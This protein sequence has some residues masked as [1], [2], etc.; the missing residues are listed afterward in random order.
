MESSE[1]WANV[2]PETVQLT[3]QEQHQALKEALRKKRTAIRDYQYRQ[4]LL[5]EP[6][7]KKFTTDEYWQMFQKNMPAGFEITKFNQRIIEALCMWSA[8]DPEFERLKEGF[9]LRKGNLLYG[10]YG[11]GKSTIM[12]LF[13][14][15][16]NAS[17]RCVSI[18]N[19]DDEYQRG[20]VQALEKYYGF[21]D[22]GHEATAWFRQMRGGYCFDDIGQEKLVVNHYQNQVNVVSEILT[23]RYYSDASYRHTHGTTNADAEELGIRYP[24]LKASMRLSEMFNFIKFHP[25]APNYRKN[26]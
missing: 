2:N 7:V 24:F 15:N 1:N 12:R 19:I 13:Q 4:K 25:D 8:E 16:Q 17:Y 18:L 9:S 23:R 3:Q 5:A 26:Q 22:L 10:P 20:G 11:C 6:E 14:I 21:S